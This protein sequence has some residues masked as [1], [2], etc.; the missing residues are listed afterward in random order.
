M[1]KIIITAAAALILFGCKKESSQY[2][3]CTVTK[4]AIVVGGSPRQIDNPTT[5]LMPRINGDCSQNEGY[6][7]QIYM[8]S[9]E[10]VKCK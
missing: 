3:E 6:R 5:V 8:E 1:K 9:Y 4:F 10:E 7:N 2:C